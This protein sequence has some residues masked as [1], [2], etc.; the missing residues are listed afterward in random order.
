[1]F[2]QLPM[3]QRVGTKAFKKDLDNIIEFCKYL[4][5]PESKLK[6]IHVAGTNGKGSIS[7]MIAYILQLQGY[8]VGIYTSPHYKDFRERIKINGEYI[9]KREVVA[10]IES[11]KSFIKELKP[12]FFEMTVALAFNYFAKKKV[13][14]AIIEVGLGGRLDSTNVI[15]PLLSI[16]SNISLDHQSML[17]D[18]LVSIAKEKAGIIKAS[19]PVVIGEWQEEVAPVF[20]ESA[21]QAKSE[22]LWADQNISFDGKRLFIKNIP[23]LEIKNNPFIAEFQKKNLITAFFACKQLKI[24]INWNV[25][26]EEFQYIKEK[27]KYIGR[28]QY[29]QR[30]P[31]VLVDSGHNIAGITGVVSYLNHQIQYDDIHIVIGFANDKEL[32]K[33]LDILPK[34]FKYYFVKANV[35]R[36]LEAQELKDYATRFNLKGKAYTS[37]RKGLAAARKCARNNDL[38]FVGG[39]IFVVAEVL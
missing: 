28:W 7:H 18:D 25:V 5:N 38:I 35:P 14:F 30:S 21:R 39:S 9:S 29:L 36:G 12:S 33:I 8:K 1:M 4:G 19:V 13:D 27:T 32:N 2:S 24:N 34:Q 10:F 22:I 16:I 6:T 17:G 26:G 20:K 37:V 11:H 15:T 23:W 3:Y 31:D